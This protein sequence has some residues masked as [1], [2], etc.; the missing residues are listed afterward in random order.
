[1]NFVSVFLLTFISSVWGISTNQWILQNNTLGQYNLSFKNHS[2]I[3]NAC[4][5]F[6]YSKTGT[7]I[8][9]CDPKI[10]YECPF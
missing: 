7:R 8:N 2:V 6:K 4:A 3:S 9:V 10:Y 1:M 5:E